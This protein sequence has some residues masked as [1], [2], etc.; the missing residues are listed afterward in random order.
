VKEIDNPHIQIH[1]SN[2]S[3]LG[4]VLLLKSGGAKLFYG[5]KREQIHMYLDLSF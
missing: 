4:Q 3:V 1:D 5:S 2:I